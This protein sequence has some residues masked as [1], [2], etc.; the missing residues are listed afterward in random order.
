MNKYTRGA[1]GW[2]YQVERTAAHAKPGFISREAG[3]TLHLCFPLQ[4]YPC[5]HVSPL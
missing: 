2:Q 5:A 1:R 3:A 4:L